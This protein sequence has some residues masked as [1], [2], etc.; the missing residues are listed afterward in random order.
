MTETVAA[1]REVNEHHGK[2]HD[3]TCPDGEPL[4]VRC[5][6]GSTI[7]IACT[8]CGHAIF[9]DI[10]PGAECYHVWEVLS[11]GDVPPSGFWTPVA[12]R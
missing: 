2:L 9:I 7:L 10:A 11:G 1:S 12:A 6:H 8:Q 5:D 4:A 3:L